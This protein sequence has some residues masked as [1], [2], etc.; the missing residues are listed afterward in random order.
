MR[1]SRS[2][3]NLRDGKPSESG[4]ALIEYIA[5]LFIGTLMV[6]GL[7]YQFNDAFRQYL[8]AWFNGDDSGYL[9]CLIQNG[10]LPGESATCPLPQFNLK[11]GKALSGIG[12]TTNAGG[13]NGSGS[14]GN[15]SGSANNSQN[16][17]GPFGGEGGG[18]GRRG[19]IAAGANFGGKGK[20]AGG[21]AG[22]KES[23]GNADGSS[24]SPVFGGGNA[25]GAGA[26]AQARGRYVPI[27]TDD[28]D[29][30]AATAKTIPATERDLKAQARFVAAEKA[31]KKAEESEDF[32]TKFTFGKILKYLIIIFILFS[33]FFFIGSQLLA[34]SQGGKK[35]Q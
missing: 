29:G 1:A 30:G 35:R 15:G 11:N 8:D 5:I 6:L 2:L 7:V 24:S 25:G 4:Q 3:K 20:N 28:S 23:T 10:Y 31:R 19:F 18:G 17:G 34:I 33:I 32:N 27:Q 21:G 12:G 26:R 16:T 14:A 22:G 13:A 9:F